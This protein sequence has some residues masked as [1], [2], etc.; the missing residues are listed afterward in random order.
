MVYDQPRKLHTS[1][2]Q[3]RIT[4]DR[5]RSMWEACLELQSGMLESR[6]RAGYRIRGVYGSSEQ[7]L[8][9]L[10]WR[11]VKHSLAVP[12]P[13]F[14]QGLPLREIIPE[15]I[16][17]WS[18]VLAHVAF[19][20]L[21]IIAVSPKICCHALEHVSHITTWRFPKIGFPQSSS[22]WIECIKKMIVNH[23]CTIISQTP[24]IIPYLTI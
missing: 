18:R 8:E 21:K 16:D 12:W 11:W 4:K 19:N 7:N 17:V 23:P 13:Q 20:I 1:N 3:D 9:P 6:S 2:N 15:T 14:S 22:I 5:K 10:H 24:N